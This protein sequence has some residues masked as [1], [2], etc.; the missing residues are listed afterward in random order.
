M[1]TILLISFDAYA[2]WT[3]SNG[4]FN[5]TNFSEISQIN[6]YNIL[7]LRKEWI[8]NSGN[9]KNKDTVQATPIFT[10]RFLIISTTNG[11]IHALDPGNGKLVWKIKLKPPAGRRG[12]MYRD[13]VIF[14]PTREGVAAISE[15][16]GKIFK[17]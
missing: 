14:V 15:K 13:G 12:F 8:Y 17:I 1:L 11:E 3:H 7:N 9:F 5:S 6:K 10:G 4:N 2:N 16:S